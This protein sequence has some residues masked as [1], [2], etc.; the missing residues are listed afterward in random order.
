MDD[1]R[2]HEV[3]ATLVKEISALKVATQDNAAIQTQHSADIRNLASGVATT[4]HALDPEV[5]GKHV[6]NH[7][8]D[9]LGEQV[10]LLA[11]AIAINHNAAKQTIDLA[12]RLSHANVDTE[13]ANRELRQITSRIEARAGRSK[14]DFAVLAAGMVIA[15]ALAGGG[16]YFYTKAN[17][18]DDNFA[19][20]VQRI[21]HYKDATWCKIAQGQVVSAN[22]ESKHCAI[23]MPEYQG[24][25]DGVSSDGNGQ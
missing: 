7:I 21:T 4:R 1:N 5:L 9:F 19:R 11:K 25:E 8:D 2:L 6:S 16:A 10:G 20:A 18:E 15:A 17:I 24:S 3:L 12:E 23:H 14:W 13:T 22:D